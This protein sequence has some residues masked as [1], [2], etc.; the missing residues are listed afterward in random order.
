MYCCAKSTVL[1][2]FSLFLTAFQA[3]FPIRI[4]LLYLDENSIQLVKNI[5]NAFIGATIRGPK[6]G[7]TETIDNNKPVPPFILSLF[8]TPL[9]LSFFQNIFSK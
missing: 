6:P 7:I 5:K 9:S 3:S 8:K 2:I 4:S 1:R